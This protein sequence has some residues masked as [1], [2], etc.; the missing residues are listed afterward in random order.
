MF[1]D[2]SLGELV[3]GYYYIDIKNG[4]SRIITSPIWY[5]RNDANLLPVKL[6]VFTVQKA[7]KSAQLDWTTEQEIN[8]SHF[9]AERSSDGRNWN[10]ILRVNAA[11]NSSIVKKYR[12]FD[13]APL[14][15]INYYRLK[16]FDV[17]GKFEYSTVKTLTFNIAYSIAVAPNPARDFINITTAKDQNTVLN[18]QLADVT[19]KMLRT[20]QSSQSLIRISTAGIA[21]GLYFIKV[22]DE[23]AVQT[24]R[25]IIE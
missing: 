21:K 8:S 6:S 11:G 7:G 19:G 9:I 24:Q 13:N 18:I 1:K 14:S 10:S 16:Q 22:K 20:I 25:V 12:A 23:N 15:G 2:V 4:T 17:D 5:T 3:T